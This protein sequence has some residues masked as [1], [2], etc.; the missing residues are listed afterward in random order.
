MQ[1]KARASAKRIRRA[2]IAT[3]G[4]AVLAGGVVWTTNAATVEDDGSSPKT[5]PKAAAAGEPIGFGA[6]TSGGAG[7]ETVTVS[8]AAAFTEAVESE[9]AKTVQV[10]GSIAID[11]MVKVSADKT[12]VGAG[13]DAAITGG[14]LNIS[15][16]TNVIVQNLT[17]TGSG[18]DAINVDG[19]SKVWIDHNT[20]S[21][22]YDGLI[23]IKNGSD[24]VTVSW[25]HL[26][27]HDKSMLLGHSDDN[28]DADTG[29]L[30]VTYDHNWFEGTGQR[31]PRVRFGNPVHV[32]NN[33]YQ[34]IGSYGVASTTNAGVLVEGNS[35]ENV[36]DPFHLAEGDSEPGALVAKDNHLVNS[37]EGETG[38][39]VAEIPYAYTA[40]DAAQVKSIVTE[41]AGAGKG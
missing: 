10:E 13:A 23:D 34:D 38:G 8:D 39:T 24:A 17:F 21:D 31:H 3:T 36:E 1:H 29:K 30:R 9:G 41:G 22:A 14:G 15:D 16:A 35:F 4:A 25:N 32:L 27:D 28:G 37:G 40:D 26:H 2:V 20:L 7:G 12:V 5:A 19:S 11:G 18:D 33:Y 6:G